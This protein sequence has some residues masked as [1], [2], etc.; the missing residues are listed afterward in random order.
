MN[1]GYGFEEF[2]DLKVCECIKE[3]AENIVELIEK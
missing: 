2:Y 1:Y 3:I